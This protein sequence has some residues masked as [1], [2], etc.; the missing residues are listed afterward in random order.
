MK[1]ILVALNSQYIHSNL[2][3]WQLK[4]C[5]DPEA[6][7]VMVKEY[8]IN[9][10]LK[11]IYCDLMKETPDV[12]AFSCYIWNIEQVLKLAQDVKAALPG[13]F[14]L[15]GGPEVSF[16]YQQIL[17][18]HAYLDGILVGEGEAS[19]PA[20]LRQCNHGGS[21]QTGNG[22]CLQTNIRETAYQ[23]IADLNTLADPYTAEMLAAVKGKI[24]Y[25]EGS[26]GCPFSCSYCLSQISHGV[27]HL[28]MERIQQTL[29]RLEAA[30]ISLVKFVDRTFNCNSRRAVAL[31]QFARD[32]LTTLRLH[33]EIGADLLDKSQL[34]VLETM[35]A[36]RIQLEAGVQ[37]TNEHTLAT[38]CRKT[39]LSRIKENAKQILA[40]GTIHFHLDLIAGLPYEDYDRFGQSFD[41]I[42]ALHPHQLQLG[43]LKM[44]K[45]SAIRREASQYDYKFR[46]Y[47]PYEVISNRFLQAVELNRLLQIEEAVE[48]YYN[49]GR[50]ALALPWLMQSWKRPFLFFESLAH[51]L[52][53]KGALSQSVSA[54]RQ[55]EMLLDFSS[56][57]FNQEEQETLRELLRC[58]FLL[59]GL[60]GAIPFTLQCES[61]RYTKPL[62]ES[63]WEQNGFAALSLPCPANKKEMMK[64]YVFARFMIDPL[65]PQIKKETVCLIDCTKKHPVSGRFFSI[66][67]TDSLFT[68]SV[69]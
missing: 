48:R 36:G 26:R 17:E 1:T 2:A 64:Q 65:A 9:Q 10:Q 68:E 61:C 43:F 32:R 53:Q 66:R 22:L 33:F 59:S 20:L 69:I 12:L 46:N 58:D 7:E 52:D 11:W 24:L 42:F 19:F 67:L 28:S 41:D 23:T 55:F 40:L 51:W 56:A 57:Y 16:D 47:A 37:S 21:L 60:K 8:N 54:S 25:I 38:V 18:Q 31:W 62:A 27:R 14:I 13:C 5:C 30:G 44:L 63:F 3:V 15:L 45:G 39:N 35:P 49:S 34:A 6:G 50:F 4:A 29:L